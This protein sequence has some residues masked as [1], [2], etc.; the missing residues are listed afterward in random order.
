MK[1]TNVFA[2][3]KD[4]DQLMR[5][6][7]QGWQPGERLFGFD[8]ADLIAKGEKTADAH[9]ACHHLALEYGLPEIEGRYGIKEDG[10]FI[11]I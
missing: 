2:K 7:N 11:T 5:L 3:K 10:E 8:S 4:V 9:V 6:A 1:G